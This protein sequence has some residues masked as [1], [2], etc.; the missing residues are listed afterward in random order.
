MGSGVARLTRANH[1][2]APDAA[3]AAA[4]IVDVIASAALSSRQSVA[5]V[6][7][8]PHETRRILSFF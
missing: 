2:A 1:C 6:D 5:G 8:M 4:E 7:C 3:T